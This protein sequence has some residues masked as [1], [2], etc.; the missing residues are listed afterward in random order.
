MIWLTEPK[1][2][3]KH[4]SPIGSALK[5]TFRALIWGKNVKVFRLLAKVRYLFA[6]LVGVF[7]KI[8]E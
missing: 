6:D 5:A 7:G 1:P 2:R 4:L 8:L 3:E